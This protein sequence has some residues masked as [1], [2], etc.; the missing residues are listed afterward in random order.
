MKDCKCN[1]Y[2]G[3]FE[4]RMACLRTTSLHFEQINGNRGV[5]YIH[6]THNHVKFRIS[7][8]FGQVEVL[9]QTSANNIAI[10]RF[11]REVEVQMSFKSFVSYIHEHEDKTQDVVISANNGA[12]V[13]MTYP[14]KNAGTF[15]YY[16]RHYEEDEEEEDTEDTEE[17][18]RRMM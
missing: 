8:F 14:N 16:L 11:T 3:V 17:E 15:H 18:R 6:I 12:P 7:G 5:L 2:D 9:F 13:M 1:E 4:I 10:E